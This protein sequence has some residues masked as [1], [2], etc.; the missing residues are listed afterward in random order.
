M[1]FHSV[2]LAKKSN[3]QEF[4]Q[5]QD[6]F[7]EEKGIHF[8]VPDAPPFPKDF[9]TSPTVHTPKRAAQK[10]EQSLDMI[11]H[12][13]EEPITVGPKRFPDSP[14]PKR[15]SPTPYH[16]P[17]IPYRK[18]DLPGTELV[19]E[20]LGAG[21]LA[22]A[23]DSFE[24]DSESERTLKEEPKTP[25]LEKN[26][27]ETPEG[28]TKRKFAPTILPFTDKG[29]KSKIESKVV[30]KLKKIY[31]ETRKDSEKR[32]AVNP[33]KLEEKGSER[34]VEKLVKPEGNPG[35]GPVKSA[36]VSGKRL[37]AT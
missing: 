6:E 27:S 2:T 15:L 5:T 16:R 3:L 25:K 13:V 10:L 31:L 18:V 21:I 33:N 26:I 4:P 17:G 32:P 34:K 20:T 22:K 9:S 24:V 37:E 29:T 35:K 8:I 1:V 28:I 23:D 7:P 30:V 14:F 19:P 36:D 11:G 12:K